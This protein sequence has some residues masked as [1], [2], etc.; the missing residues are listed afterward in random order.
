MDEVTELY[1]L[2]EGKATFRE[3]VIPATGKHRFEVKSRGKVLYD[4]ESYQQ[5]KALFE[6]LGKT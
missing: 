3:Y 6:E 4:G 2:H 5:A 1:K